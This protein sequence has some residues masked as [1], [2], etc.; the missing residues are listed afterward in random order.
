[1]LTGLVHRPSASFGVFHHLHG[2]MLQ[3]F[4]FL[5][6]RNKRHAMGL[7]M[8]VFSEIGESG[9]TVGG[10]FFGFAA[11]VH[12]CVDGQ[13]AAPCGDYLAFV[14]DDV[15]RENR[16]LE[17]DAVEYEKDSILCVNILRHSEI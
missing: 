9:E 10:D 15:A 7:G 8:V 6:F 3:E 4:L 14:G 12:L 2:L 17:V 11:A 16:E 13:S 1:M 5:G